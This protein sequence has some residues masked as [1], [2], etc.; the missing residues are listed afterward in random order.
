MPIY[1]L[2]SKNSNHS[3]E[4]KDKKEAIKK[5]KD[6]AEQQEIKAYLVMNSRADVVCAVDESEG[7]NT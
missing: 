1:A 7:E 5:A 6:F 2:Y 3:I 4:A